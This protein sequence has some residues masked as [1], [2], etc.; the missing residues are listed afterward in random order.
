MI[1]YRTSLL[2]FYVYF[3]LIK[4]F[5]YEVCPYYGVEGRT[6][7]SEVFFL[8]FTCFVYR[9]VSDA[10]KLILEALVEFFLF[11]LFYDELKSSTL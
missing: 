3:D 1:F 11:F 6:I 4:F 8:C 10:W 2:V 7:P 5:F 9:W